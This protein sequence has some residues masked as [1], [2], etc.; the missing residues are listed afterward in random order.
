ML[1]NAIL[2]LAFLA[3]FG[4]E[5]KV[6]V[7]DFL[8]ESEFITVRISPS[9][10]YLAA[11]VPIENRSVLAVIRIA[12]MKTTGVFKPESDAYIDEFAWVSDKR[13][14]FNT[15]KKIGRLESPF[16]LDGIWAM[17][18]DGE[19][20]KRFSGMRW[21]LSDLR[22][23]EDNVLVEYY[24]P[25]YGMTYGL[26][27]VYTGKLTPSKH[28]SP[29]KKTD[30]DDGGY[31]A[32]GYG[33]VLVYVAGRKGT[34]EEI[35]FLRAKTSDAWVKF[36]D[37]G[38]T[39]QDI[40]FIGF[41]PNNRV[42]YFRQQSPKDGPDSVV[43]FDMATLERKIVYADDNVSPYGALHSPEDGSIYAIRLLDGKPRY[44]YLASD[45]K[46]AKDHLKF[47]N[48][49]PDQD[50][51]PLGY[52]KDGLKAIY[53]V[54]SDRNPG[55]YYLYDSRTG[56]ADYLVSDKRWIDP[57]MM[58]ST[59][60]ARFKAR[61]GMDI[62]VFLT[63]PRLGKTNLPMVVYPHGGPFG[64]FDV[65]GFNSEVQMLSQNGYA[66]LQVNFRGSGNYGKKFEEAGYLQWGRAMQD[67]LTDAT[68]WAV[69]QGFADSKRVCLYGA[70]YGGYAALM[71]LARE[72]DLYACA[73][74]NVG[75]YDLPKMLKEDT[76]HSFQR[77][78]SG[79]WA[80]KFFTETLGTEGLEQ[81]SPVNLAASIK[82]PVLLG[83][84]EL[85]YTAPAS[86]TKAMQKAL[87]RA[88]VETRMKVYAN[89][90]HGNFLIENQ[91]DWANR[92]LDFLGSHIGQGA[93]N[94]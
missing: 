73:I 56:K 41:S 46:Y 13:V 86:Q 28:F 74:G 21:M 55:D 64:V 58:A 82:A 70:S 54:W 14:A 19:N 29:A 65:W 5:A 16:A 7:Q 44:E 92:V 78:T 6:S 91:V 43:S 38:E 63:L 47:R 88:G 80:K 57:E 85:D 9:G 34:E 33:N 48:S 1:R 22:A 81:I 8:K 18:A 71:G 3:S 26:Q 53:Y 23:D 4:A 49:F 2:Y 40:D 24:E 50:V 87:E 84:G 12:D 76:K 35:F 72:P 66:V 62:E 77:Y 69:Q 75:V 11:T 37:E 30:L 68:R 10:E 39:K 31:Y 59:R 17:D 32:D 20:K 93:E 25:L 36:Y 60:A 45:S 89:E 51:F 90:G 15:A 79:W 83:A 27:N 94:K 61:D 67:D 52:T 42:V